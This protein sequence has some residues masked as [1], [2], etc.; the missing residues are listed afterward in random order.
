MVK[1]HNKN[2][3]ILYIIFFVLLCITVG[4]IVYYFFLSPKTLLKRSAIEEI[5]PV[6]V[7]KKQQS[8]GKTED[9]SLNLIGDLINKNAKLKDSMLVVD[10]SDNNDYLGYVTK[11]IDLKSPFR[12]SLKFIGE[13][14]TKNVQLT[15]NGKLSLPGKEWWEGNYTMYVMDFN[16]K[17]VI[18]LRDGRSSNAF[19]LPF[20]ELI[21][22][23]TFY[24]DFF[25]SFGKKFA[26]SD[27]A[28]NV[29]KIVEMAKLD[30][31]KFPNG[32]FPEEKLWPGVL[33]GPKAKL[34]INEFV[35]SFTGK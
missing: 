10:N 21:R 32:L 8:L 6:E 26:V 13:G 11:P 29:L 12:V 23:E 1:K 27:S 25:D 22:G 9:K 28:G 24:I 20:P 17:V 7:K 19:G 35:L 30:K 5:F 16:D 18:E 31:V 34:V 15:L 33:V 2:R 3:K 14:A 4:E